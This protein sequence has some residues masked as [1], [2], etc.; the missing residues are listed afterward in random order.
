MGMFFLVRFISRPTSL[1]EP[2]SL[3]VK[4]KPLEK[5]TIENLG[6]REYASTIILA[7]PEPTPRLV[8][9]Q[10]D[11]LVHKFQFDSD[12]KKVTGLAHIPNICTVISKCPVIV[13]FRGYADKELFYSGYGTARSAVKYAEAEFI[14]IAPDF[15][16]YGE[17]DTNA[18]NVYESRF[19][20]YTTA[21]NLLAGV[22]SLPMA[23]ADKIGIWGHS[24]GGHISLTVLEI[25]QKPYPTTLWAPVSAPFP[26]SVLFYTYDSPDHGKA[27][28]KDLATFEEDYDTEKYA[29]VN[30][31][32]RIQAPLQ[33]HQGTGDD[34]I[35][36]QW[37]DDLVKNL[38]DMKKEVIYYKYPG[39]DHNM[40]PNAWNVVV[41]RDI[42][43]FK[44]KLL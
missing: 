9:G 29:L 35:P 44:E 17:S 19:Q 12:G 13:Q 15:L 14:S 33:I 39:A 20:T 21:L 5:Y 43:F 30:Y 40:L 24:N 7:E 34:L 23:D 25:S 37:T 28:R 41:E 16:G 22:K 36:T 38:T 8:R 3:G 4:E 42:E 2:V 10:K 31:L 18:E 27:T 11:Y 26:Y 32:D 1:A 6:M